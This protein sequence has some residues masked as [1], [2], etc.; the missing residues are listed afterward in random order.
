V[1]FASI[2]FALSL[3]H[4]GIRLAKFA[5]FLAVYLVFHTWFFPI[6]YF[7]R[8]DILT[9][10]FWYVVLYIL[11]SVDSIK[12]KYYSVWNLSEAAVCA[13]GFALEEDGQ[14]FYGNNHCNF[15]LAEVFPNIKTNI[16]NWNMSVQRWLKS[17]LY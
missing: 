15:M 7:E 3:K 2:P 1:Q 12:Y 13:A 6:G 11:L 8:D 9:D 4:V 17:C 14:G 5:A 10:P 16:D